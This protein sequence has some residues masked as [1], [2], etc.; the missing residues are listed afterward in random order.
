VRGAACSRTGGWAELDGSQA[1]RMVL[2][3]GGAFTHAARA[4]LDR[5]PHARLEKPFELREL[6]S[7]VKRFQDGCG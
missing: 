3:T 5:V 2:A 4:F 6:R 7:L 1:E